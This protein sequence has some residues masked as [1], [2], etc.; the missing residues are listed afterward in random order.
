LL[1]YSPSSKQYTVCDVAQY[2]DAALA[3]ANFS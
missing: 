1:A 2:R 3:A